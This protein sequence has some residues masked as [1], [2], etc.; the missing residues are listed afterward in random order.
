MNAILH[1]TWQPRTKK[2]TLIAVC[3]LHLFVGYLLFLYAPHYAE[4]KRAMSILV[5]VALMPPSAMSET[6]PAT[7]SAMKPKAV[8]QIEN[9][10]HIE[11]V[12]NV[13]QYAASPTE[14]ISNSAPAS[15][16]TNVSAVSASTLTDSPTPTPTPTPT[17]A[18]TVAQLQQ[19]QFD[20]DY[21]N[22]P[23]PNYPS[24]SRRAGEHGRVMVRVHVDENGVADAVEIKDSCGFPRLDSAA[25]E[26]VRKWKFIAAKLGDRAVPAWV[27][28]PINFSL[29]G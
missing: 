2:S 8:S 17:Q 29:R 6:K 10:P 24:L 12:N 13:Q 11:N 27:V 22:N 15:P 5:S 28:V 1:P 16:A 9:Q 18:K 14:V 25:M 26:A 4:T 20:A 19:P 21:L 23:S 3:A 7:R